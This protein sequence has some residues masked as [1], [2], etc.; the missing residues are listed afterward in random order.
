MT[1]TKIDLCNES[2]VKDVSK[3]M[4]HFQISRLIRWLQSE[5]KAGLV[6]KKRVDAEKRK[7]AMR[8]SKGI[9]REDWK[10]H[11]K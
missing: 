9:K 4:T 7:I 11:H 6:R 8:E 1:L 10:V 3:N 5:R 2:R